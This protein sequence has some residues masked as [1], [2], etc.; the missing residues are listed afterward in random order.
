MRSAISGVTAL[1]SVDIEVDPRG[2]QQAARAGEDMT[3]AAP[4][5]LLRV[6]TPRSAAFR[7]HDRPAIDQPGRFPRTRIS[8]SPPHRLTASTHPAVRREEAE[9]GP[10]ERG[11]AG[12]GRLRRARPQTSHS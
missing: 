10:G 4:D 12:E 7:G 3:L 6:N 9:P 5:Q 2:D 8:P 1:E 11:K